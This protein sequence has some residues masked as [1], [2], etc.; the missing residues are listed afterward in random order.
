MVERVDKN[1]KKTKGCECLCGTLMSWK[2]SCAGYS[3]LIAH[4]KSKHDKYQTEVVE[5]R[6]IVE[7]GGVQST[8]KN[9]VKNSGAV[10]TFHWLDFIV[11]NNLPFSYVE[12]KSVKEYTKM[13]PMALKTFMKE[14]RAV[15]NQHVRDITKRLSSVDHLALIFDAW[16]SDGTSY[17]A[18]YALDIVAGDEI[19][20]C[21]APL[22]DEESYTADDHIDFLD[23]TL[24]WYKLDMNRFD[25]FCGDNVSVNKALATKLSK[26]LIGCASHRLNLAVKALHDT[27]EGPLQSVQAIMRKWKVKSYT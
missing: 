22:L 27:V 12:R 19:L 26:P 25:Y 4:V 9:F 7:D 15:A 10:N 8:L 23:A 5:L 11:S 18:V 20:L 21:I 17:F 2:G 24:Q 13:K 6:K 3:A 16:S 1:G 14:L